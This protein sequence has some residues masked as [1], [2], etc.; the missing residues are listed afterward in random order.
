MIIPYG[1]TETGVSYILLSLHTILQETRVEDLASIALQLMSA[2][3]KERTCLPDRAFLFFSVH[4]AEIEN[5]QNHTDVVLLRHQNRPLI[6]RTTR[7]AT[8]RI[9]RDPMCPPPWKFMTDLREN[10]CRN[11]PNPKRPTHHSD[12][13]SHSSLK[14]HGTSVTT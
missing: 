8:G 10:D 11:P 7:S 2:N 9:L 14:H 5:R 4:L 3:Q 12:S 1:G 6:S 13:A